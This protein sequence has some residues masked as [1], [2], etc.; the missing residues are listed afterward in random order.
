MQ[1]QAAGAREPRIEIVRV[2]QTNLAAPRFQF[3]L[4]DGVVDLMKGVNLDSR[5]CLED[6][7]FHRNVRLALSSL[8]SCRI[9]A[10]RSLFRVRDALRLQ[11]ASY[12]GVRLRLDLAKKDVLKALDFEDCD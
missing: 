11:S 7:E 9:E 8:V 3:R 12:D 10:A 6:S 1:Q 2:K 5:R 4:S